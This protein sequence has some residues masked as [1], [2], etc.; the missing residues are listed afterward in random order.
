MRNVKYSD[1]FLDQLD[2]NDVAVSLAPFLDGDC[3]S[4]DEADGADHHEALFRILVGL[5]TSEDIQRFVDASKNGSEEFSNLCQTFCTQNDLVKE[6]LD[7]F[8]KVNKVNKNVIEA[9]FK[10]VIYALGAKGYSDAA[11][12]FYEENQ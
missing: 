1:F 6:K 12:E 11:R 3:D 9:A 4:E 10:D 8:G 7:H 5:V 2:G